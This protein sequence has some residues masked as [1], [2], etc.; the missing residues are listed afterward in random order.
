MSP[1]LLLRPQT[2][3]TRN[4]R[5]SLHGPMRTAYWTTATPALDTP[6]LNLMVGGM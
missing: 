5:D 2:G 1:F 6:L 3:E 4:K